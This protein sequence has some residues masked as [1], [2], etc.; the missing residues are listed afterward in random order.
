MRFGR[1]DIVTFRVSL[2]LAGISLMFV[3]ALLVWH[4]F[5]Q[6]QVVDAANDAFRKTGLEAAKHIE[7]R[8]LEI[9]KDCAGSS[10]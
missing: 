9:S 1:W 10:R 2:I 8:L 3:M 4:L 5:D 6:S 7:K